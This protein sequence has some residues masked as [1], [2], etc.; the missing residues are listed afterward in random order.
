MVDL[1]YDVSCY[2]PGR[3]GYASA[4]DLPI[5]VALLSSY[6]HQP[7]DSQTLFVG[8]VDLTKQVRPPERTYLPGLAEVL[9][10]LQP[11]RIRRIYLSEKVASE[12]KEMQ[13]E[14]GRPRIGDLVEIRGVKDID[15][16]V[17]DLWPSLSDAEK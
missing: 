3:H 10:S 2:I 9:I 12:F 7:V 6:L 16:L 13:P 4:L 15:S 14:E 17:V 5:I 1:S 8:E 11:R